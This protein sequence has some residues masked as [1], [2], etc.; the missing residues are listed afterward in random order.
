[1][2][3]VDLKNAHALIREY[4]EGNFQPGSEITS[5]QLQLLEILLLDLMP[6]EAFDP[7]R[8]EELLPALAVADTNWNHRSMVAID[9]FYAHRSAGRTREAENVRAAFSAQ[10]P[11]FWYKH[12]LA[13]L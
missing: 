1:V 13:A 12:I 10:C 9:E 11:S 8:I 4:K 6:G 7:E 5:S 3:L 2:R